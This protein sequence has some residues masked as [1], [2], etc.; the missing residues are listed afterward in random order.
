MNFAFTRRQ[1]LGVAGAA[2]GWTGPALAQGFSGLRV[3][4][5]PDRYNVDP[6]RFTF[7]VRNP[8]AQ[9]AETGVRPDASF[10]P[11]PLLFERWQVRQGHYRITLRANLRHHDGTALDS[12]AAIAALR[13]VGQSRSDFLQI[14]P[15][16]LRR[17]DARNFVFSSRTGSNLLIENMSHRATS[18]F[19]QHS[20]RRVAPAGT[21]PWRFVRY[22]PNRALE[23]VRNPQYWGPPAVQER[24]LFQFVPDPMTRLLALV[25]G[26]VD[27]IA[28]VTPQMLLALSDS[29]PVRLHASRPVSY[30]ALLVNLHG[31]PPFTRLADPRV[32]RALALSIDRAAVARVLYAGRGI[33]ARGLLPDWMFGLGPHVQGFGYDPAEASRLLDAAGWVRGGRDGLRTRAGE[34]LRL[35]LVAAFPNLAA[36]AP[37]PE[38]LQ[39]MVRQVGIG[40]E[41]VAV[42][43]DALYGQRF[44]E[45]GAGDLFLE[46]ASN[47]NLDPTFLLYNLFHSQTPWRGYR[48]MAAGRALDAALDQA[49]RTDD[50]QQRLEAV[51][52]AHRAVVDE[53]VAA[54]AVLH[55][56]QFVL[57]RP[58][59]EVPM[60]EHRDWIDYG[61]VRPLPGRG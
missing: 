21:G 17:L 37:F 19:S 2:V 53:A 52:R 42:E 34:A 44:L 23:L 24:M 10:R 61:A 4:A 31:Q 6:Q 56:P 30:L 43:D 60:F 32:R 46:L 35:R 12:D 22:Q 18:L 16:S 26:E 47:T 27:L 9:I 20:D 13:Q 38:L 28:E 5:G 39:Q 11:A 58:G 40:I 1:L 36:V 57:A 3:A 8:H 15:A 49:R 55:V 45:P 54:I 33:A 48:H 29:M 51:R 59:L 25:A 14:D 7:T 41:I 50:P